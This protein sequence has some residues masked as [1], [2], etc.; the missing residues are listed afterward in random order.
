MGSAIATSNVHLP[1]VSIIIVTFNAAATLQSCLNSIYRQTYPFLEIIVTDGSS[2]D[3]TVDILKANESKISYWKS[4]PDDGIYYAMNKALD[5]IIGDHV[6]FLGADDE[7]F[8]D[9]SALLYELKDPTA[10][11]YGRVIIRNKPTPGPLDA[12]RHA[13]NTICHQA[14]V[15][16]AAVFRKYKYDTKYPITADHLLNMQCWSDKN[17]HF[18]FIDLIIARFNETGV[19]STKIDKIFKAD[20]ARLILKHYGPIIW[21]RYMTRKLKEKLNPAKY[22]SDIDPI[23]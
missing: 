11:Y 21:I 14:I 22:Q 10:I 5:H 19:S 9:F 23:N 3:G 6:Y 8:D 15:Y 7:L 16:P 20:Q 17:F 2:T 18:E 1:K 12:Y 4:E 13:S